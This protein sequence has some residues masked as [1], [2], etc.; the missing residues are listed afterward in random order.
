[1]NPRVRHILKTTA[2][3]VV[4]V[5]L[6]GMTYQG[7]STA[8]ER[9]KYPRP[10]GLIDVGGH[11]LHIYCTGEG[12]P[13]VILEAA[14]GAFSA[15][16]AWVQSEI[17][18]T[19]RVC[20]YDRAGLGWSEAGDRPFDP[21][22][23]PA[24]LHALLSG[25]NVPPPYVLAGHSIGGVFVRLYA[26]EYPGEVA[27]VAL[28][29]A[30]HPDILSREDGAPPAA[31]SDMLTELVPWAARSG[32]LRITGALSSSV[33]GLPEPSRGAAASFLNRPDHLTR[34][35]AEMRR[36]DQALELARQAGSLGDRPLLIL[37]AGI[38]SPGQ[39]AEDF[40]RWRELQSSY[41]TLSSNSR[42]REVP[43]ASHA[44]M[45]TERESALFIARQITALVEKVRGS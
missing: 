29:D 12:S 8:V 16:W 25:G 4:I 33:E 15:S 32:L 37:P 17:A 10:G 6:A 28:I 44:S 18:K 41:V 39:S 43:D 1:M 20:S 14:A 38:A 5:L 3:I 36:L 45:L 2:V 31:P 7:V 42:L 23:V 30:T 34:S 40:N 11:Q 9:R 26:A 27:A 13:A 21:A 22:H 35:G 24:E 19:T